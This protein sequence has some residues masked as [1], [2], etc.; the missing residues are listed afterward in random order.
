MDSGAVFSQGNVLVSFAGD[1]FAQGGVIACVVLLHQS[2][3]HLTNNINFN[4]FVDVRVIL[5]CSRGGVV[6]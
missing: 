1:S 2:S 6:Q 3:R 4:S 5:N